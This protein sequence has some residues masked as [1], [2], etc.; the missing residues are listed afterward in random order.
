MRHP[1]A[2]VMDIDF[3]A[4][5]VF[6]DQHLGGN[7]LFRQGRDFGR[8]GNRGEGQLFGGLAHAALLMKMGW[9]GE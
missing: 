4:L 2:H 7:F 5:G 9:C 3:L 6:F 8:G 1:A